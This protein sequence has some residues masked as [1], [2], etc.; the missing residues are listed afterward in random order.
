MSEQQAEGTTPQINQSTP[1]G[2]PSTPASTEGTSVNTEG[3]PLHFGD[4][5]GE[6][7][8]LEKGEAVT[9]L[10][11]LGVVRVSGADRQSWLTTL[12][13]Q[14]IT[15]MQ[16]GQSRELLLL[17][18]R[19][20][21]DFAAA[22][23]DDGEGT[24]LILERERVDSLVEFLNSMKFMLRVEVADISDDVEVF[25][26]VVP[27]GTAFDVLEGSA[28]TWVD[29]WPDVQPGGATYTPEGFNHPADSRRRVLDLI[30]KAKAQAVSSKYPQAGMVAWEALRVEDLRPRW[31]TEVDAK[32]VPHELDWLRTAVHIDKGCYCG[33][34]TV[35]RILN[36]GRPPR[37]LVL[38][39]LD[40]SRSWQ[41]QHG[42]EVKVG[43][44]RVG[45]VTTPVRHADY[46]PMALALVR[47]GLDPAVQVDVM[48]EDG[49]V[50]AA[51]EIVVD[52]QGKSSVSPEERPG[53]NL[54]G[55]LGR[56]LRRGRK[57]K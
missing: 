51:Q 21:I 3:T 11:H 45:V 42:D 26:R 48:T 18:V 33:Q 22:V 44:R 31:A 9:P 47:R 28:F 46:G 35:A 2:N 55:G 50:A 13:S 1:A 20:H 29:P 30:P 24:L 14:I 57:T 17:D 4:M 38:L 32:A 19:G 15:G 37:R 10:S 53:A 12:S 56:Q 23:G 49:P 5:S 52:P 8:A 34:E 7:W 6:Q 40:G 27:K 25:G 16:P 39:Q 41:A 43:E 36:L 54:R